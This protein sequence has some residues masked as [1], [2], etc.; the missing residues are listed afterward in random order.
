MNV[1]STVEQPDETSTQRMLKALQELKA[2]D[3]HAKAR[4]EFDEMLRQRDVAARKQ[5]ERDDQGEYCRPGRSRR[6]SCSRPL[7]RSTK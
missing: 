5:I 2:S 3:P 4:E 6:S 1:T 7:T